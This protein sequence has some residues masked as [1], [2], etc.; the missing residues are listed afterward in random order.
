MRISLIL[1]ILVLAFCGNLGLLAQSKPRIVRQFSNQ[2]HFS[3]E[4]LTLSSD[5]VF[6]YTMSCECNEIEYAKGK[7][8]YKNGFMILRGFS[9][10]ESFPKSTITETRESSPQD[11]VWIT[12]TDYFG[13]AMPVP[14]LELI[15]VLK[16]GGSEYEKTWTK[17]SL[18]L[19]K[20]E[21][22]GF[23]LVYK[24]SGAPFYVDDFSYRYLFNPFVSKINIQIDYPKTTLFWGAP[25]Q[26]EFGIR[27]YLL[28]PSGLFDSTGT[29][30]EFFTYYP[31]RD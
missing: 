8:E 6:F 5:S 30:P 19:S 28:K 15:R 25:Q 10:K 1:L 29:T 31:K 20:A 4:L 2:M 22:A 7:W 16:K 3:G 27:T 9:N 24:L 17:D 13:N 14:D 12:A 26:D 23:H 21:Y 11:S 18:V